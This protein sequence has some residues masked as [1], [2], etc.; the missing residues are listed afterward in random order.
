MIPE[1]DLAAE[2]MEMEAASFERRASEFE[3]EAK[4][5]RG[6]AMA[7]RLVTKSK[8]PASSSKRRRLEHPS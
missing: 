8:Q 6:L 1:P 7:Y 2:W 4:R 5:L 3:A